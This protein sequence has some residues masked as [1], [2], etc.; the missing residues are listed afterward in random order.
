MKW[1]LPRAMFAVYFLRTGEE[2]SCL[3]ECL[4]VM[5]ISVIV[6]CSLACFWMLFGDWSKKGTGKMMAGDRKGKRVVTGWG[7]RYPIICKWETGTKGDQITTH[8]NLYV[9][10]LLTAKVSCEEK[11]RAETWGC[12]QSVWGILIQA[13]HTR[14]HSHTTTMQIPAVIYCPNP[15]TLPSRSLIFIYN[16][17]Y[18][19]EILVKIYKCRPTLKS[20]YKEAF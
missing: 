1:N 13:W 5:D 4:L 3:T 6:C 7:P 20:K 11:R 12:S 16:I 14:I 17:S 8:G 15:F 10:I 18:V 2:G 9:Q 19:C